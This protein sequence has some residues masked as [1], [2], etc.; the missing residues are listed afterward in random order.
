MEREQAL[1]QILQETQSYTISGTALSLLSSEAVVLGVFER[2]T[3]AT[4]G[5]SASAQT[6]VS[7]SGT[8][9][10]VV[11]YRQRI[12]LPDNAVI[13]V[14]LQDTSKADA[15]A[16]DI[17][18][19]TIETKGAQVPIPFELTYDPGQIEARMLYTLSVRI[20]VDGRLMWINTTSTPVLTRDAPQTDVTVMVSPA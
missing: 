18:T 15:A 7:F 9:T 11:L 5:E 13:V 4:P 17:A 14:K 12:A 6:D 20:T 19:A 16:T 2:T 10:G 1:G 8:L 3:T